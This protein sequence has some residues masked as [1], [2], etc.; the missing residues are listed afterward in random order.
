MLDLARVTRVTKGGKRMRFRAAVIVGDR[1][2]RVGF[3]IAKG[4]DVAMAVSKATRLGKK[5]LFKVI[6]EKTTIPHWVK[7]KEKA[8]RVLL[9]PAPSGSG[10]IA[11]GAMRVVLELAGVP[12]I[13]GKMLGANNKVNN[14]RATIKALKSLKPRAMNKK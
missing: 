2:G 13:V 9:K 14:A 12:D 8:A 3:G 4:A 1:K 11:G 7:A 10:I 5:D 6:L